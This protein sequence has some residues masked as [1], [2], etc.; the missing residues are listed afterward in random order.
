MS[1]SEDS[2]V[3]S[4]DITTLFKQEH[5]DILS[6]EPPMEEWSSLLILHPEYNE[7]KKLYDQNLYD[8]GSGEICTKYVTMS[9][10]AVLRHPYYKYP[11]VK[12]P[13]ILEALF[14]KEDKREYSDNGQDLYL[15][16]CKEMSLC[17]VGIFHRGLLNHSINLRFYGI[18]P[19]GVRAMSISLYNNYYVRI[20][21]FT[22]N[23]LSVDACYHIGVMLSINNILLELN[24][25]GCRIEPEGLRALCMKL[26]TNKTLRSINLSHNELCDSGV[27]ILCSAIVK[28]SKFEHLNLSSN[29]LSS[30]AASY[31]AESIEYN[32]VMTDL[33]IS[34]N[35][36]RVSQGFCTLLARL[37]DSDALEQLNLSWNNLGRK[38]T[39]GIT[40]VLRSPSL[41][42]LDLSYNTFNR[43]D[44]NSIAI[45]LHKAKKLEI[46][47]LSYN[48]LT[49]SDALILITRLQSPDVSLKQLLLDNVVVT[50]EFIEMKNLLLESKEDCLISHGSVFGDFVPK[51]VDMREIVVRRADYISKQRK[52]NVDIVLVAMALLKEGTLYINAKKMNNLYKTKGLILDEGLFMEMTKA[53]PGPIMDKVRTINVTNLV[54]YMKRK[55]PDRK[56]PPTPPPETV[57]KE[58]KKSKGKK[59]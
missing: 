59:K 12:N 48:P 14:L 19:V 18:N 51:L 33:D 28:G 5:D 34:R 11:S 2:V 49:T 37:R 6:V 38:M 50:T 16:L 31:L 24:L 23:V 20:I 9:D 21:D 52:S 25:Q 39:L 27:E 42:S 32:S 55:W 1:S 3:H 53:F 41:K 13:G 46:L 47:N 8:P 17:P 58:K 22:G 44:I 56:L 10:S 45:N 29:N 35:E 54:E 43:T 7:K 57:L 40:Y 15:D 30:K 4:E 26:H 36:F